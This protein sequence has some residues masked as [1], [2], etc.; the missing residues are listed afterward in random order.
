MTGRHR[1]RGD[2]TLPVDEDLRELP[3][4]GP[5]ARLSDYVLAGL[6]GLAGGPTTNA[7]PPRDAPSSEVRYLADRLARVAREGD[8]WYAH[9]DAYLAHPTD[10]DVPLLVLA[11]EMGLSLAELLATALAAAV[12]EDL[13]AGRTLAYLQS[14]IGG[15]R[16]TLGLLAALLAPLPACAHAADVIATGAAQRTG[17]IAIQG[18]GPLPERI[19]CVPSPIALGLR[20]FDADWPGISIGGGA[21]P[22]IPLAASTVE[23]AARHAHALATVPTSTLVLRS[24]SLAEARAV[25]RLI[26]DRLQRRAALIAT[27]RLAGLG[28]WLFLRGLVPVFSLELAPGE[29]HRLPDIPGYRGPVLVVCGPDGTIERRGEATSSWRLPTPGPAERAVLWDRALGDRALAEV[30][31]AEHR[32][33]S[34]RIAELARSA[35]QMVLL[36]GR[37]RPQRADVTLAARITE[38]PGLGALAQPLTDA[39]TDDVLVVPD[40]L[41]ADL[42][43]LAARCRGRDT[44]ADGLGPAARARYHPG[45][46]TLFVGPSGTG[47]TLAAS[48][49]AT[50]LGVP[51]YRV[52]L[53]AV[54]SKYIGETE[55]HLAQLIACAEH[56]EIALL[57][58][59]ADSLFGKRTDVKDSNDRFANAQT[60]YLLQRIE[61][62]DGIAILTSNSRARFDSAFSRRLDA[63][64]DF[65]T[66]GP[67]ERRAL[68][69]A[70]L[71]AHHTLSVSEVNQLAATIDL[72]GGHI[73]NIVFAAAVAA[74]SA[75]RAI[76]PSDLIRG[77]AAEYRKLG[78]Q[79]PAGLAGTRS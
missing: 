47:K 30:L 50:T 5:P 75:G 28:P 13:M 20:G 45:V 1:Q 79:A 55:K 78:R 27:D 19:C 54:T 7:E 40:A 25:A 70:H 18:E 63:I 22:E 61:T 41:R 60:N 59:E 36:D 37:E 24:G 4:G 77:A 15:S 11:R 73:R 74:R 38:A 14:P 42:Q 53:A 34:G 49:L 10:G 43:A 3:G 16:P 33:S 8:P 12:D 65:P 71:G 51:L 58:D 21:A 9:L 35:R 67:E 64:L 68:W 66:P 69:M 46:R 32:H 31:A 62:F 57:F 26:A 23:A 72:A 56:A 48:W 52:D 76:E 44:L 39:V 6:A 17:M 29:H 2:S